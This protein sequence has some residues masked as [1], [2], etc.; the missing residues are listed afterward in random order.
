L[1]RTP[2]GLDASI[3][4]PQGSVAALD[5]S[6]MFAAY[7]LDSAEQELRGGE[8]RF[9]VI[10]LSYPSKHPTGTISGSKA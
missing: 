1:Q 8:H 10:D 6:K 3:T 9:A 2:A 4:I 5:F 7:R